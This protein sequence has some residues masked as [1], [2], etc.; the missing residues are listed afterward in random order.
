MRTC[1]YSTVRCTNIH[2]EKSPFKIRTTGGKNY[3]TVRLESGT[4]AVP[5]NRTSRLCNSRRESWLRLDR[6]KR[7]LQPVERGRSPLKASTTRRAKRSYIHLP[8][9]Q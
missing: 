2:D 7:P 5:A 8:L 1:H 9:R 4:R 6:R 3:A